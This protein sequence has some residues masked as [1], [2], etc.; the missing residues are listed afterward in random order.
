MDEYQKALLI[1]LKKTAAKL[2]SYHVDTIYIGGGTPSYYGEKRLRALLSA[3]RKYFTLCGT[4]EITVECNPDS[5]DPKMMTHLRRCGFNR[6][7]LGV[8]SM[9]CE[10]LSCLHRIHTT[11]QT[12]AAVSA[13]REA[14]IK[15]LSLDLIYGL[16]GQTPESWKQTLSAAL[17][18][19]PE[20][21]SC[22]GLKVEDG[23]PLA[24]RVARGEVIPSDDMQADMYLAAVSLLKSA[25][26]RQYEISN[27]AKIGFESRHNLK[28]WMGREYVGFGPGAHSDLGGRRF[29]FP[30]DLDGYINGVLSDHL[31]FDE[32]NEIQKKERSE[33]Y[34]MFRMRTARGIEEWEY[35]REF[36]SDFEPIQHKLEFY[37]SKGWAVQSGRRWH[38]TPEGFL[39]SN[40]LILGLLESQEETHLDFK[41]AEET[42][43]QREKRPQNKKGESN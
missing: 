12:Q 39:L 29:S 19:E 33:E 7:S 20:H 22:Y 17:M 18:L 43:H 11:E 36:L 23:T 42:L 32:S 8:Q 1:H 2:K 14:K 35:R 4:P 31:Q 6:V 3:V 21:I 37:E 41:K 16:P 40:T 9:D 10:Q 24:S 15:N 5:V 28:Y 30:K 27:F 25:G 13:I 38:F 26:F 34:I